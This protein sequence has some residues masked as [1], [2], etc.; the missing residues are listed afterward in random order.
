MENKLNTQAIENYSTRLT[1]KLSD[2]FFA[3]NLTIFGHQILNY[4]PI[5]Q[6]NLFIISNLFE[7]WKEET[8][9]LKSPFF[10]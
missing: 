10:D 1:K 8:S 9:K 5:E 4:T 7:K 3:K 2:E 6:V